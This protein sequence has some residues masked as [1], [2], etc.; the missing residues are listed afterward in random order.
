[1]TSP[2]CEDCGNEPALVGFGQPPRW[3]GQNCFDITLG[4]VSKTI[5]QMRKVLEN[6]EHADVEVVSHS[7]SEAGLRSD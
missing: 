2:V 4:N 7:G 1:M 3:L 6:N 5:S